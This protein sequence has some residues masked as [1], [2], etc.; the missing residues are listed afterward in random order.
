MIAITWVHYE[1]YNHNA[2]LIRVPQKIVP[3]HIYT[4]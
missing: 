2:Q 1:Y 4:K 3:V